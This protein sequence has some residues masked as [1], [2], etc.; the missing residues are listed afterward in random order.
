MVP[1]DTPMLF[2]P[3]QPPVPIPTDRALVI[4][5]SRGCDLRLPSSDSSRR[6]AEIVTTPEGSLL[7]DLGSTNGSFVNGRAVTEHLLQ[8]GD[9]IEIAGSTITFCQIARDPHPPDSPHLDE[10]TVLTER[11]A[12]SEAFRG[13]LAEIPTFAVLQMLE[14]GH[15]TGAVK[16]E[17]EDGDG[18]LWLFEGRP[19]HAETKLQKG[20]DAAM[21]LVNATAGRFIFEPDA[22]CPEATIEAS[23]T[24]L[25]LESAR[26]IDEQPG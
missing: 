19:I 23:V 14:M 21:S 5:R 6:H 10:K 1:I 4:G 22:P 13:D 9:R 3:P 11:L 7:R 12:P 15:K 26:L 24:E 8:P 25:L 16:I 2:L 17:C 20:F 18:A